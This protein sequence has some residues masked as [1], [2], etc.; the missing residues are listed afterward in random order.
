L[1]SQFPKRF[2]EAYK[3]HETINAIITEH[4]LLGEDAVARRLKE[5]HPDLDLP[6]DEL[7]AAI[8]QAL[9]VTPEAARKR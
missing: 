9:A 3:I 6:P 2:R 7:S 5:L 8:R 4:G 1:A